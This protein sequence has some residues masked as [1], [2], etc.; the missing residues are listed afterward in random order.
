MAEQRKPV[1]NYYNSWKFTGKELDEETG[2][3]Y[4]G[5]RYYQ[6]SWSVW[7][8]VDPL[9]TK[10]P[11]WNPYNYTMNNPIMLIDPDGNSVVGLGGPCKTLSC[12]INRFF[13]KIFHPN[14][15]LNPNT[16]RLSRKYSA[17]TGYKYRY[18]N[19]NNQKNK[20]EHILSLELLSGGIIESENE[21]TSNNDIS[22]IAVNEIMK[23]RD[24]LGGLEL[25]PAA[26]TDISSYIDQFNKSIGTIGSSGEYLDNKESEEFKLQLTEIAN[27]LKSNP[28][29]NVIFIYRELPDK[30]DR[31]TQRSINRVYD[32]NFQYIRNFMKE[33]GVNNLDQISRDKGK[34]LKVF[35]KRR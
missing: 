7:L 10:Y 16:G 1:A 28:N 20:R 14:E 5:A 32:N 18:P 19:P 6:P 24:E 13:N 2:L 11:S 8:S 35:I 12:K 22:P 3:Y 30:M 34:S 23:E 29:S 9:L 15:Q 31:G 33:S 17:A 21:L 4:I 25:E 27:Y 26:T